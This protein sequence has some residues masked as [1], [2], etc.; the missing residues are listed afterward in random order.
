MKPRTHIRPALRHALAGALIVAGLSG[1]ALYAQGGGQSPE[2]IDVQ[3]QQLL[4]TTPPGRQAEVVGQMLA[5][6]SALKNDPSSGYSDIVPALRNVPANLVPAIVA[7]AIR[8]L[9]AQGLSNTPQVM[10]NI[11]RAGV[12]GTGRAENGYQGPAD[13]QIAVASAAAEAIVA[14]LPGGSPQAAALLGIAARG[15]MP[16]AA[17]APGIA[18]AMLAATRNDPQ[19]AAALV[20]NV[21]SHAVSVT[22]GREGN[23]QLS[24][25]DKTVTFTPQGIAQ[26]QSIGASVLAA[27][28]QV[29]PEL[30]T[31]LAQASTQGVD[32][33]MAGV[34]GAL[35]SQ[36]NAT[37]GTTP[38]GTGQD[39]E[40]ERVSTD[41]A[42]EASRTQVANTGDRFDTLRQTLR[43]AAASDNLNKAI[44]GLLANGVP[45]TDIV[46]A[47]LSGGINLDLAAALPPTAAGPTDP[48]APPPPSPPPSSFS[49]PP[50]GFI[51]SSPST[52]SG[53]GAGAVSRS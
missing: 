26:A 9:G 51:N 34:R 44:A 37:P 46:D 17:T 15:A 28:T 14:S 2:A 7:S 19:V 8:T 10:E 31:E 1:A 41:P 12:I 13:A 38:L 43:E 16:T 48:A 47:A 4:A 25:Q 42:R 53:G 45:A 18:A 40:A 21:T 20:T 35:L 36:L 32:G 52:F 39:S 23:L 22:V 49:A 50:Q 33:G 24:P 3:V 27:V 29:A 11:V 30:R 5:S 6:L